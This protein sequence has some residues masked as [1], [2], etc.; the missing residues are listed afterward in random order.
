MGKGDKY[1]HPADAFRKDMKKKV[2]SFISKPYLSYRR[3]FAVQEIKRNKQT[4]EVVRQVS[5]LLN[6]PEKI[7]EEVCVYLAYWPIHRMV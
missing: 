5:D 6:H 2:Y 3:S 7:D 1:V 4:R